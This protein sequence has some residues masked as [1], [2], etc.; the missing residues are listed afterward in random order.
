M[1][2]LIPSGGLA[3]IIGSHETQSVQCDPII[4]VNPRDVILCPRSIYLYNNSFYS[5][6]LKKRS[7]IGLSHALNLVSAQYLENSFIE[8]Y[9]ILY[10]H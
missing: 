3:H 5:P 9:K 8:F 10:V 7:N 6:A 4:W 1:S 2:R